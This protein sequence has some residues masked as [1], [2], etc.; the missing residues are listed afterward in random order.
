M[1]TRIVWLTFLAVMDENGFAQFAAIGNVAS[2]ARVSLDEAREAVR[3]LEGPDPE[4]S[5]QDNEGRRIERIPGGWVVL[6]AGK[7]RELITRAIVQE[8]TRERVRRFRERKRSSNAPVTTSDTDTDTESESEEERRAPSSA[9]RNASVTPTQQT[10]SLTVIDR[11]S[12]SHV[13]MT[14]VLAGQLPRDHLKHSACSEN[15]AWCV[16]T[17][18]HYKFRGLLQPKYGGSLQKAGEALETWYPTVWS[19]LPADFVMSDAFK[20][21]Q[22]RFDDHFASK[23]TPRNSRTGVDFTA[24]DVAALAADIRETDEREKQFRR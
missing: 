22:P 3:V 15:H 10:P 24:A 5:D 21:W 13:S 2:R 17:S 23:D 18:V 6:N 19:S 9:E 20:F 16:P 11:Q 4:S 14:P 7:H 8:Q 12:L 1:P